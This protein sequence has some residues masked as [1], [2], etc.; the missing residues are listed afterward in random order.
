VNP[1][2]E[3]KTKVI[4]PCDRPDRVFV[5]AKDRVTWGNQYET[6]MPGK[7]VWSTETTTNVFRLFQKRGHQVAFCDRVQPDCFTAPHCRMV[8][9]EVI[10]RSVIDPASSYAKRNPGVRT[11]VVLDEPVIEFFLK[12]KG[13]EF[14]G[15][16]LPD[17]DPLIVERE[18]IP[19]IGFYVTHP[20]GAPSAKDVFIPAGAFGY[21][22]FADLFAELRVR[23]VRLTRD[24]RDAWFYY[25]YTLSDWKAEFGYGPDGELLLAD[26]VDNDSW[27]LRSKAGEEVSKQT[28][29]DHFRERFHPD[30]SPEQVAVLCDAVAKACAPYFEQVARMARLL[31]DARPFD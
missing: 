2:I 6:D 10:G 17:A 18:A 3:G 12:T 22:E 25:G 29:R 20:A 27:R 19:G 4:Q 15:I 11:G 26:V 16:R 1:I 5:V 9:L 8:P 7:A 28:C 24:L 14:G 21:A 13:A 23:M 30:M 31:P